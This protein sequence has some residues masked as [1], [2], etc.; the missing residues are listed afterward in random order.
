MYSFSFLIMEKVVLSCVKMTILVLLQLFTDLFSYPPR[1]ATQVC[2]GCD[3]NVNALLLSLLIIAQQFAIVHVKLLYKLES[4][5]KLMEF[6]CHQCYFDY[7]FMIFFSQ[8]FLKHFF[9]MKSNPCS[10]ENKIISY[11]CQNSVT[12]FIVYS[13]ISSF[14]E[15]S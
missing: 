4:I 5:M 11:Q 12:I 7:S 2:F 14:R 3:E 6:R 15:P 13:H 1:A 10:L 8:Y 9:L